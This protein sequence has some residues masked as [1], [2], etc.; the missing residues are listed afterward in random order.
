MDSQSEA[1]DL[2]LFLPNGYV[3]ITAFYLTLSS[4]LPTPTTQQLQEM[5]S[6]SEVDS[7]L[8]SN[9]EG[10]AQVRRK[11]CCCFSACRPHLI[12]FLVCPNPPQAR[13]PSHPH[14]QH[15]QH[16]QPVHP[17]S[18]SLLLAAYFFSRGCPG[19]RAACRPRLYVARRRPRCCR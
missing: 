2:F 14:P 19:H 16:C 8:S 3:H 12:P 10:G 5:S 4:T 15:R 1:S 11:K 9:G 18:S 13:S 6:T 17:K 7:S